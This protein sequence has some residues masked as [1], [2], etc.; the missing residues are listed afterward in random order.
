M[1]FLLS[2]KFI[3]TLFNSKEYNQI[4]RYIAS[5]R[6]I[7]Q[8]TKYIDSLWLEIWH[9]IMFLHCMYWKEYYTSHGAAIIQ[10]SRGQIGIYS[11]MQYRG[12]FCRK[13]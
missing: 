1:L 13:D 2:N 6:S 5:S 12:Y 10:V 8:S 9:V 7:V 11:S 4:I 3:I